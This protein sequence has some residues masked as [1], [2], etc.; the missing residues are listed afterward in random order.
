[1]TDYRIPDLALL[2]KTHRLAPWPGSGAGESLG[3]GSR[4]RMML[5]RATR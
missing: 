2:M 3:P 1:M 5:D 4:A